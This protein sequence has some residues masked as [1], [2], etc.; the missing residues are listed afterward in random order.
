M[1]P[2]IQQDADKPQELDAFLHVI[3]PHLQSLVAALRNLLREAGNH[4]D[5]GVQTTDSALAEIHAKLQHAPPTLFEAP[6]LQVTVTSTNF[7]PWTTSV[8][9]VLRQL[10]LSINKLRDASASI[11]AIDWSAWR[12]R[13]RELKLCQ[14]IIA[15]SLQRVNPGTLEAMSKYR[16][17]KS[18]SPLTD[19]D[20]DILRHMHAEKIDSNSPGTQTAIMQCLKLGSNTKKVF[21]NLIGRGYL[22]AK[23]GHGTWITDRGKEAARSLRDSR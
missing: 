2:P 23:R 18:E 20:R 5:A 8:Q 11:D 6:S 16:A 7:A 19:R 15:D 21:K 10:K 1:E 17:S 3:H 22:D 12:M 13:F 4:D 9:D 14:D